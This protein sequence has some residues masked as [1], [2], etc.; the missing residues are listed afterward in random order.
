MTIISDTLPDLK[1]K[2]RMRMEES[3]PQEEVES[4]DEKNGNTEDLWDY[5]K[6]V[7]GLESSNVTLSRDE[8]NEL[9]AHQQTCILGYG[10][11]TIVELGNIEV[12]GYFL[13][14]YY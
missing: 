5:V 11:P 4:N 8:N 13:G 9:G 1:P 12:N 14:F 6:W 7:T 10:S 2:P 3:L